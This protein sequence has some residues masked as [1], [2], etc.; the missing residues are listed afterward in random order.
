MKEALSYDDILLIPSFSEIEHRSDIDLRT[1]ISRRYGALIPII[2][3]PMDTICEKEM[4]FK[5]FLMGGV[6]CI[7][8]FMSIEEQSKQI[9]ELVNLIYGYNKN[10]IN[11]EDVWNI[12]DDWHAKEK[13]IPIMAA[14]GV[15]D[16]DKKRAADVI[17]AGGNILLIDV[18][19]GHHKNVINMIKWCKENLPDFVDI[20]A[21]NIVTAEG[22][23]DLENAGADGIRVGIGGGSLCETR[24]KTGFGIPN[25]TA[26]ENVASIATIPIIADGGIKTSGDIAKAIA[27]GAS[28]VMLGSLLAG[29]EETPG[30]IIETPNG[31]YKRYRGS[32]SLETKITHNQEERNVEG[33]S[34]IVPF[35]GGVKFI[36]NGLTDGLKSALS[37]SGAKNLNEFNPKYVVITNAGIQES[38]PHLLK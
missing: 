16:E 31:L 7:H 19:H 2:A 6:G 27:I 1:L 18:A 29:T 12:K 8:R 21:G 38:K 13:S 5:M 32:A 28:S 10:K 23:E 34:T 33:E 3:S 15:K 24:T 11:Y 9:S 20:I 26:I 30:R 36:I 37:Y 14:I 17:C 22:A 35:K 25:I 4:A